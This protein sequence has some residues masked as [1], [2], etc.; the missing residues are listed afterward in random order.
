[1]NKQR[2]PLLLLIIC[3]VLAVSGG[4]ASS[5]PKPAIQHASAFYGAAAPNM[6]STI[7]NWLGGTGNWSDDFNWDTG[8]PGGDSDVFIR[9]GNDYVF[10][11][12]SA[13]IASLTL[14]G[15][16][17]SSSLQVDPN[18]LTIAGAL[19]VNQTG[20]LVLAGGTVTA[21]GDALNNGTIIDPFGG[22]G[23]QLIVDGRL[24][25]NGSIQLMFGDSATLGSA[26]NNGAILAVGAGLT[27]N[28]SFDNPG[29]VTLTDGAN[30]EVL[31]NASNSGT[32]SLETSPFMGGSGTAT[33]HGTFTNTGGVYL[34]SGAQLEVQGT[35]INNGFV[36]LDASNLIAG[37]D[38]NNSGTIST[39]LTD[40][41]GSTL[42]IAG[43]LTNTGSFLLNGS[44]GP[45]VGDT[46]TI[47]SIVN[48]G[49]IDLE[50]ASTL[51]VSG[52]VSN[53]GTISTSTNA[54]GSLGGNSIT[55]D[56]TLNN[57]GSF[58]LN[59]DSQDYDHGDTAMI[60]RLI[61]SGTITLLNASTLQVNGDMQNAG[62]I[63]N[64]AEGSGNGGDI[65]ILGALNNTGSL[66]ANS[67]HVSVGGNLAN[68]G[69]IEGEFLSLTA[70]SMVNSGRV[71]MDLDANLVV[72]GDVDNSGSIG[73][74]I[75]STTIYGTLRNTG[76]FGLR[77]SGATI[78]GSVVNSGSINLA[79][80]SVVTGSL[81]NSGTVSMTA[82]SLKVLG[83]ASNSGQ[84][85]LY[86]SPL[87]DGGRLTIDGTLSNDHGG[88]LS[89]EGASARIGSV[90]NHGSIDL[91]YAALQVNRNVDNF[92]QIT[93]I[94]PGYG[95]N[96]LMV[97][98]TLTNEQVGLFALNGHDVANIGSVMNRGTVYIASAAT[99]NVTGGSHATGTA[100]AGYVQTAGQTTVDGELKVMGRGMVNFAGGSV[101]G[102]GGTITGSVT[103][104]AA[105]NL[106]DSPLT[107]GQLTFVGN[108]TQGPLGSLTI[109]IAGLEQYDQLNITGHA[110]LNGL[111]SIDLL[112]NYVPQLGDTF[113]IMNFANQ[114]GT[115]SLV[116][117]LPINGEEHFILEYNPTNLTLDVVAGPL[118]SPVSGKEGLPATVP[119]I[120]QPDNDGTTLIAS[121]I[122]S[123]SAPYYG[124]SPAT[125][126][127]GSLL[128]LVSGLL[129]VGYSVR[130]R[131]T[132]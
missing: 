33:I 96:T 124:G 60:G 62:I 87:G 47:G 94:Y 128:L 107:V 81:A 51:T 130:R 115:F 108:Y 82:S 89:M 99:L 53:A 43:M 104:N 24:T 113:D 36:D 23:S 52:D 64:Y 41:G 101:Y 19:T 83:D 31:G 127:P 66:L 132:K 114:S 91:D 85:S 40:S 92:G 3:A 35:L 46:A 2:G 93:T 29:T 4:Y 44:P 117:G 15:S 49:T 90:V 58:L 16:S 119:F 118:L 68:S 121:N 100:L 105:I 22:S 26:L 7:D 27:V 102:N 30:L 34:H 10:L 67:V 1:M 73:L 56:G 75:G 111:L 126:E 13:S 71:Y 9:T 110:Q 72:Y 120:I 84:L 123:G 116:M 74:Y 21:H 122:E 131:M 77:D 20:T 129:C 48:R 61:N 69:R 11:D 18:P 38:L 78:F 25:N 76:G 50:N 14:G 28:T 39:D 59:G 106:G 54:N 12:T 98:G 95:G 17:G 70:G 6:P 32:L 97:G 86:I 65:S 8:L 45:P 55:I 37:G 109:D 57:T 42:T 103:S 79:D 80:A 112:D 125:P 63:S 88:V 5:I